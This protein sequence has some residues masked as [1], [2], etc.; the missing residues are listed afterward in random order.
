[1]Q[2]K[3]VEALLPSPPSFRSGDCFQLSFSLE[4]STKKERE[5]FYYCSDSTYNYIIS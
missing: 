4:V 2:A 5:L 3:G 1:M